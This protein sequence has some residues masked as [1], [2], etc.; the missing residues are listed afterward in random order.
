MTSTSTDELI[1]KEIYMLEKIKNFFSNEKYFDVMLPIINGESKISLRVLDWFVT[2]YSKKNGTVYNI[3]IRNNTECFNVY[4]SYKCQLKGHSKK[5]FDP[6]CRKKKIN[7][8][9]NSTIVSVGIGKDAPA[10]GT[11]IPKTF[12]TSIG[13]LNFFK[14][15]IQYKIINYILNNLDTIEKD[16]NQSTKQNKL[17][18]SCSPDKKLLSISTPDPEICLSDNIQ[19]ITVTST[20]EASEVSDTS[21]RRKRHELS[22]S[23]YKG[24]K[25]PTIENI[26]LCFD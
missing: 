14:W 4:T 13:Q 17:R 21:V 25:K 6:F 20:S 7:Y 12:I 5:Y 26:K 11:K 1:H 16:M 19:R 18:D 15:A 22:T 8:T 2:N 23:V 10:L 9:Y 24:M 3:N